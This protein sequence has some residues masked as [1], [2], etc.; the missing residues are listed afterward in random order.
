MSFLIGVHLV[1]DFFD[2]CTLSTRLF[3]SMV[4]GAHR[5]GPLESFLETSR[6]RKETQKKSRRALGNG[7]PCVGYNIS[8]REF[9]IQPSS[10]F[11][12][13]WK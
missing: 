9:R 5:G 3:G 4:F 13:K 7:P 2:R 1:Q 11:R 8:S 6:R 12:R 10:G